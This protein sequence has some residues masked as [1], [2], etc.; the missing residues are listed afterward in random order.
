MLDDN[1]Y[2]LS[3]AFDLSEDFSARAQG[4][5]VFTSTTVHPSDLINAFSTTQEGKTCL[6]AQTV[7]V[8]YP[9]VL[10]AAG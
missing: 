10:G 1:P 5:F 4:D 2:F 7:S 6:P 9:A 3:F 8:S